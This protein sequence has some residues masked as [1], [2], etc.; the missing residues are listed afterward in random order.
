[1]SKKLAFERY[2][3]FHNQIKEGKYPNSKKLAIQF[4]I[5]QKQAQRDIDF[6]RDR[7]NA[8]II[9]SSAKKGYY[10]E[11]ENYEFPPLW[12]KEEEFIGLILS[13]NLARTIPD[14][15]I[16]NSIY[17]IID[18]LITNNSNMKV[19]I[20]DFLS[21]VSVK[22]VEYYKTD[23][24]VFQKV[25]QS[26]YNDRCL[27][28]EYY[29]PHKKERTERIIKPLHLLCYMGRWHLIAYCDTRKDLRN[30]ALSRIKNI[31]VTDKKIDIPIDLPD[32]NDYVNKTFG[33]MSNEKKIDVCLEFS[34]DVADWIK[35]QIWHESQLITENEDG[36]ICL[37]FYVSDFRELKGE[38]LKYGSAVKVVYPEELKEEIKKEIEKMKKNYE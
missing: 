25:I 33:L 16:K 12:L 18:A 2:Y 37:K 38:I 8:P 31:T 5:S 1:M 22:N 23:E 7:L 19:S 34:T 14:K 3:W 6:I 11:N 32:M 36:S 10:Y 9:Y 21:K 35:E 13:Y 15:K 28:I 20:A 27:S 29:S 4:E 26:L 17:H 30:F 24:S